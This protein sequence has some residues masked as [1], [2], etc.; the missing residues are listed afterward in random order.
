MN[1][2]AE[3]GLAQRESKIDLYGGPLHEG[4]ETSFF[5]LLFHIL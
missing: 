1:A 5:N 4:D 2:E 3:I